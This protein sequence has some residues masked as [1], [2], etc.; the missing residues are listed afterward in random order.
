[1][2]IEKHDLINL[3]AK[4]FEPPYEFMNSK[5]RTDVHSISNSE[6]SA[7][8]NAEDLSISEK[9]ISSF[10]NDD[11]MIRFGKLVQTERKITELVLD[12]INEIERRKIYRARAYPSLFEFL[13]KEFGYSPSSAVRRI[14]TARLLREIPA[15]SAKI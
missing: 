12:C 11:L 9:A 6:L 8:S 14:E 10:S 5:V 2:G 7:N 4:P 3:D 13:V 1:M 15:V